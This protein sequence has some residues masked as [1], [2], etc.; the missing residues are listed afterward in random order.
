MEEIKYYKII[1]SPTFIKELDNI[2]LYMSKDLKEPKIAKMFYHKIVNKLET[3]RF[4]PERHVKIQIKDIEF[5]KLTFKNYI[6]I[7]QVNFKLGEVLILH[8]FH[9][10]QNYLFNI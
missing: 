4:F 6:I 1:W 7:Y 10:N 3:L 8:I 2:C 5:R 9:G